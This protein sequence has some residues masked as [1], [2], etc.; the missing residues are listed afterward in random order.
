MMEV[1]LRQDV[2][3]LGKAGEMVRVK[4]GYAR[5]FLL[6]KGLAFEAT[7]GNKKR[8]AAES[9]ARETRLASEKAAAGALATKLGAATVTLKGKAGEE[10]KLFG[11]ITAQDIADALAAQGLE[12]DRRRI[13]LEHSIKTL[14]FHSV[15]VRL[16]P[17]VHAEVKVNVVAE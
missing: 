8:I 16:H 11:S 7:E 1:I 4:P 5:N 13:E 9:K 17:E 14:G 12:I 2:Q 10:G 15:A 3:S 6:P